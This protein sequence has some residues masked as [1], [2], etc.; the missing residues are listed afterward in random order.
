MVKQLTYRHAMPRFEELSSVN[1]ITK[2]DKHSANLPAVVFSKSWSIFRHM[3]NKYIS[4][5]Y[6]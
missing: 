3:V 2:Q 5:Y 1:C 6:I 4:Q